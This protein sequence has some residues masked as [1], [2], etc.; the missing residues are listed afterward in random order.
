MAKKSAPKS[1]KRSPKDLFTQLPLLPWII[2]G[3]VVIVVAL[4]FARLSSD[5]DQI[6]PKNYALPYKGNMMMKASSSPQ[7]SS[8]YQAPMMRSY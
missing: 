8:Y 5:A 4:Y 2:I 3:I 7:S 1:N 6:S